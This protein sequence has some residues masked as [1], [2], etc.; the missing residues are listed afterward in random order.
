MKYSN[1]AVGGTKC[2][3][4]QAGKLDFPI[5]L[6]VRGIPTLLPILFAT[7]L[8]FHIYF[9]LINILLFYHAEHSQYNMIFHE[10]VYRCRRTLCHRTTAYVDIE[11][12]RKIIIYRG[13]FWSFILAF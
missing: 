12:G 5:F 10:T 6:S 8:P 7:P 3:S 11:I 4:P 2:F 13:K 9:I 1:L